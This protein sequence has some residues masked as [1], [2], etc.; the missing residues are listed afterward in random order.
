MEHLPLSLSINTM[1]SIHSRDNKPFHGNH[2]SRNTFLHE[3]HKILN[4][5]DI[6]HPKEHPDTPPHQEMPSVSSISSNSTS[7]YSSL[8]LVK[9]FL[10]QER[11]PKSL[12][13][14]LAIFILLML[15]Y[16]AI[17]SVNQQLN[18]WKQDELRDSI[19]LKRYLN[20]RNNQMAR[21]MLAFQEMLV[22]S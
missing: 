13:W 19:E 12:R 22:I 1:N 2:S 5:P 17:T 18:S 10:F 7:S 6:A 16:L 9:T 3:E 20:R 11:T 15:F 21:A 4:S 8:K 14:N